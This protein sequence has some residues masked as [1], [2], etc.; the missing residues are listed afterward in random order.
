MILE[1]ANLRGYRSS[2]NPFFELIRLQF[3]GVEE[4][5]MGIFRPLIFSKIVKLYL[6]RKQCEK[7]SV[8][9]LNGSQVLTKKKKFSSK[10]GFYETA[11]AP[12]FL[13]FNI[14]KKKK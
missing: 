1:K 11:I 5:H 3:K 10:Q 13:D 12:S 9:P 6:R 14:Q 8:I 7:Y 2:P 4:R